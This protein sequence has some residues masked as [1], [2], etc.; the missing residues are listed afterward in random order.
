MVECYGASRKFVAKPTGNES[1]FCVDAVLGY[2]EGNQ[3]DAAE[4]GLDFEGYDYWFGK[5]NQF[6]GNYVKAEMVKAFINS[7]EYRQRFGP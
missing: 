6:N 1:R 2:L 5:L 7:G 4:A 3:N